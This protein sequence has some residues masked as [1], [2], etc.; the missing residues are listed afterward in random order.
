MKGV[1]QMDN[2]DISKAFNGFVNML[3]EIG[4]TAKLYGLIKAEETKK[5]EQYYK[6]GKKYYSLFKDC[7][8]KDLRPIVEKLIACDER[9]AKLKE[10]LADPG[11][12]YR[13]VEE[14]TGDED[15]AEP[16]KEA[17]EDKGAEAGA[18]EPGKAS[19][20]ADKSRESFS[21]TVENNGESASET[22]ENN[23]ESFSEMEENT[24]K[25][26]AEAVNETRESAEELRRNLSGD[27]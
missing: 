26:T 11:K 6:L 27:L 23:R 12:D 14:D 15:E 5:Q 16:V 7:P 17:A 10:E 4:G 2:G 20:T 1:S 13:D 9:I 24:V 3:K 8:E 25:T 19:E 18:D 21:E 22:V